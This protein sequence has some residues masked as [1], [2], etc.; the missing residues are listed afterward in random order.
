[1]ANNQTGNVQA[2][3]NLANALRDQHRRLDGEPRLPGPTD[4]DILRAML[5]K[6]FKTAT[7]ELSKAAPARKAG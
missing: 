3:R 4:Q 2:M 6:P 5:G 7:V 1:M